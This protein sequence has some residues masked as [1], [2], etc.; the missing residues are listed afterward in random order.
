M[1]THRGTLQVAVGQAVLP[2]RAEHEQASQNVIQMVDASPVPPAVGQPVIEKNAA[3]PL[4]IT[5]DIQPAGA[6]APEFLPLLPPSFYGDDQNPI[7]DQIGHEGEAYNDSDEENDQL[8]V[9]GLGLIVDVWTQIH[10]R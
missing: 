5:I 2:L 9:E 4:P 8:R 7:A 10:P 3:V 1:T 6:V